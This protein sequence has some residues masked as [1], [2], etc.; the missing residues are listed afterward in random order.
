MSPAFSSIKTLFFNLALCLLLSLNLNSC[1]STTDNSQDA[2]LNPTSLPDTLP[3]ILVPLERDT[4]I[5]NYEATKTSL[6]ADFF[7]PDDPS[8]QVVGFEL[9]PAQRSSF[10]ETLQDLHRSLEGEKSY[11]AVR[12]QMSL[13]S[14]NQT[15]KS[16]NR[17]NFEPLL[18]LMVI[19]DT[20]KSSYKGTVEITYPLRPIPPSRSSRIITDS[21]AKRLV[22]NW[23]KLSRDSINQ[24]LYM[25]NKPVDPDKNRVK[26]YTFRPEDTEGILNRL[27]N[28]PKDVKN[29]IPNFYLYLGQHQKSS[30]E[31]IQFCTIINTT[32]TPYA[33]PESTNSMDS[34]DTYSEFARP[35]PNYCS[36]N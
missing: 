15:A 29:A 31:P 19:T 26:Y 30:K 8:K 34:G 36:D 33:L 20:T 5:T 13:R 10:F 21:T 3:N 32:Y 7:Y 23:Q 28:P 27:N 6:E 22:D 12:V 14:P 11:V 1:Q 35:C 17:P 9:N 25:D 24:T 18:Q 4:L 2:N 16:I